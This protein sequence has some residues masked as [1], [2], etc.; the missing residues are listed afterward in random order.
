MRKITILFASAVLAAAVCS[1]NQ[2]RFQETTDE[3]RDVLSFVLKGVDTR[4][5]TFS[6]VSSYTYR[7]GTADDGTIFNLEETVTEMG[8]IGYDGPE[9]KGTPAYTENVK[10][11]YGNSFNGVILDPD[12]NTVAADGAFN[13]DGD[14]WRRVLGFNPWL[15]K[16]YLTF[17]LRMPST[18]AGVSNLAYGYDSVT[19]DPVI[20]F[21]YTS[22]TSASAQQDILFASR[23]MTEAEYQSEL[24]SNGGADILFRHALTGVKFAIGNN[25]TGTTTAG[26]VETFITKVV[27]KG[28]KNKGSATFTPAG[29]ETNVDDITEFSSAGS[30]TWEVN[31]T[32]TGTFTQTFSESDIQ[33]FTSGDAVGAPASFYAAGADKNLNKANASLTFWFIPQDIS[34]ELTLDVTFFIWDGT[35]RGDS[36]TLTLDLGSRIATQGTGVNAEWKAGQLRTF[37]LVPTNVEVD[38]TDKVEGRVKSNVVTKNT[39]NK[40]AWLRVVIVGNWVNNAGQIVAP[41]NDSQGTFVDLGGNGAWEEAGGFWYYKEKVAP[42]DVPAVPVF[43]S[44]TRPATLPT[45]ATKLIMDISVQAIAADPGS[46]YAAAWAAATQADD[47]SI[48]APPTDDDGDGDGDDTGSGA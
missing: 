13:A 45:G 18:P 7:L 23:Q 44:Y 40:D 48:P 25:E 4:S 16:D 36:M 34:S 8:Y 43:S 28:L 38:I 42:G 14:T 46:N 35:T 32:S 41:W 2:D 39:G 33:D 15:D 22:P 12:G 17:F 19:D 1:C 29:T 30:I 37:R 10:A 31:E 27:I 21:D 11:L 6:P 3:G 24:S 9:T 20:T 26:Q 5:E 47:D